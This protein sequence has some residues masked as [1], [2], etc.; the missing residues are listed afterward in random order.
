MLSLCD[1]CL[2]L[3]P[4]VTTAWVEGRVAWTAGR[5]ALSP[6]LPKCH[7]RQSPEL[8]LNAPQ[9]A[10]VLVTAARTHSSLFAILFAGLQTGLVVEVGY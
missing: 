6:P 5:V 1:P 8:L 7:V 9:P 3:M 2:P 4:T 10:A